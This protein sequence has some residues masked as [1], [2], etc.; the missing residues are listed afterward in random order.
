M[1]PLISQGRTA[2]IF[3]FGDGRVLKLF[4]AEFPERYVETEARTAR[5]VAESGAPVPKLHDLVAIDGRRGIVYERIIG[6][7]MLARLQRRP[8]RLPAM[9][10]LLADLLAE[11]HQIEL[12]ALDRQADRL[13]QQIATA[14]GLTDSIRSQVSQELTRVPGEARRLCHGDFHPDNVLLTARGPIVIDWLTATSGE[15]AADVAR[16]RL[17]MEIAR[18]VHAQSRSDR[19]LTGAGRHL[20]VARFLSRYRKRTGL[21]KARLAAWAPIVAAARLSEDVAGEQAILH[22]KIAAMRN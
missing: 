17:L 19:L 14:P 10:R 2:E 11:L 18:P 12:P 20:F 4:F 21:G 3:Q 22:R 15:P 7:T 16:S 9:A 8:W 5:L 13:R 6:E 1:G